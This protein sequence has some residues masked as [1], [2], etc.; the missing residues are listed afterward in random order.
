MDGST[1]QLRKLFVSFK[2]SRKVHCLAPFK[3]RREIALAWLWRSIHKTHSGFDPDSNFVWL[4]VL[5]AITFISSSLIYTIFYVKWHFGP[6]RDSIETEVVTGNIWE[7]AKICGRSIPEWCFRHH[8]LSARGKNGD[9]LVRG[10]LSKRSG[11]LGNCW[12]GRGRQTANVLFS[13]RKITR[14]FNETQLE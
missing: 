13:T 7:Q 9:S 14:E 12:R 4:L 5:C 6:T 10:K 3:A 8:F 11:I 1:L 2:M